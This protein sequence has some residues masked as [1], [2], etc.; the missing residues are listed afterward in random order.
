MSAAAG[1]GAAGGEPPAGS[2]GAAEIE[3]RVLARLDEL[4]ADY[5]PIRIDPAHAATADFCRVYSWPPE[6]SANCLVVSGRSDPPR[7]AACLVA[8]TR[9]VDVNRTVRRWLGVRKASFASPEEVVE[10]TGMTPH[11]VTP[12]G[13]PVGLAVLIDAALM[14]L[15]EIV[16]GG[17]SRSLKVAVLPSALAALPDASV[18]EGL[19]RP[20]PDAGAG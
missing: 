8:A 10:L 6:R 12:F 16:V 7:H 19:S 3:R 4:G 15:P 1:D 2:E 9:Q 18:V 20:P 5:R 14:E 13:L 11:G 17:G